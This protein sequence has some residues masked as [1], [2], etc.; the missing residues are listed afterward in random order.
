MKKIVFVVVVVISLAAN[1][2]DSLNSNKTYVTEDKK[3]T[4]NENPTLDKTLIWSIGIEPS[5]PIGHFHDLAKFG[6]GGSLKGEIKAARNVVIT[7]NAGYIAYSGKTVDTISYPNFK[8]WP[9][10]GGLKLYMGKAYLH[11]QA[12][13]G[14]G[15]EH[16]GTSFWY[17]AGLGVNFTK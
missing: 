7:V 10:M 15:E 3:N 9:V 12:G 16:L 5:I 14:F 13:A 4:Y 8:Y 17:G 11:G 6:F 2:Q 1:A